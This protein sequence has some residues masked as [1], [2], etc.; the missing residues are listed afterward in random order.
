[1]EGAEPLGKMAVKINQGLEPLGFKPERKKFSPHVTI[2]RVKGGRN[3]D[4]LVEVIRNN[5]DEEFGEVEV[6]RLILKKSVLTPKGPIYSDVV[7][8]NL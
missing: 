7:E 4:K 8:V 5:Q 6:N 1:M 3:K 2:A